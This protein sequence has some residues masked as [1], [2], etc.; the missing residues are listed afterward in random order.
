[1]KESVELRGSKLTLYLLVTFVILLAASTVYQELTVLRLD[2]TD[3]TACRFII[4]DATVR[5]KQANNSNKSVNAN[6]GHLQYTKNLIKA[7]RKYETNI[8]PSRQKSLQ[9]LIG[10]LVSERDASKIAIAN[11]VKN[12]NLTIGL[13]KAGIAAAKDLNC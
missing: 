9:L 6:K 3:R 12:I 10:Y 1:M 8:S 7:Y 2:A 5:G 11:T 13:S 4:D